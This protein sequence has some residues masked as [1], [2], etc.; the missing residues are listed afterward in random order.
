MLTASAAQILG[1]DAFSE[2]Y[3][4]NLYVKRALAGELVQV[5]SHL[6]RGLVEQE[7]RRRKACSN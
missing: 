4:E 3:T 7:M 6:L 2:P 1:N 5:N